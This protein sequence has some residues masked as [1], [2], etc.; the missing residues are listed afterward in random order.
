MRTK[1]ISRIL[2]MIHA[3][4]THERSISSAHS[5]H[6]SGGVRPS[7]VAATSAR[8][9]DF[10]ITSHLSAPHGPATEDGRTPPKFWSGERIALVS[11]RQMFVTTAFVVALGAV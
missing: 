3:T 11:L 7:S 1:H 10:Q 2:R 5:L 8:T 6:V 4:P 9:T